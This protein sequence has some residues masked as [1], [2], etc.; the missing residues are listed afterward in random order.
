[1]RY[2]GSNYLFSARDYAPFLFSVM[3]TAGAFL[4]SGEMM[5][6]VPSSLIV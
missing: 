3:V 5:V 1:L 2:W 6:S 4:V